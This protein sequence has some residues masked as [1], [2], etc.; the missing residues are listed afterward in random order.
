MHVRTT[1]ANLLLGYLAMN[2]AVYTLC[3]YLL[4]NSQPL[5]VST[6][7]TTHDQLLV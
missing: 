7:S 2:S 3:C 4:N 1:I 6:T 5:A